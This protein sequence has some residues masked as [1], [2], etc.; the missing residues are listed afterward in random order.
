VDG[1]TCHIEP[2]TGAMGTSKVCMGL[3]DPVQPNVDDGLFTPCGDGAVCVRGNIML[4]QPSSQCALA[5]NQLAVDEV[6]TQDTDCE[7]GL[8]CDTRQTT[9]ICTTQCRN[10][11]DCSFSRGQ[12]WLCNVG[13]MDNLNGYGSDSADL[14]GLCYKN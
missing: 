7:L 3:C 12:G 8:A 11:S 5:T 4:S 10:D 1:Q 14:I 13:E 9:P 6:C 2:L